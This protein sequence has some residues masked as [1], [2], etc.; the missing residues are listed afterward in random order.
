MT[1]KSIKDIM[2]LNMC[3]S[4]RRMKKILF[5]I[6]IAFA[7]FS[8]NSLNAL[9]G[10]HELGVKSTQRH[11]TVEAGQTSSNH[12]SIEARLEDFSDDD[13]SNESERK[14]PS[15]GNSSAFDTSILTQNYSEN[16]FNGILTAHFLYPS[17]TPLF[18]FICEF[19]I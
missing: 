7:M 19:R 1:I 9:S 10:E 11:F 3:V 15:L 13:D 18:I 8:P 5:Y 17:R 14:K 4:L 2:L 16:N 12:I 6:S